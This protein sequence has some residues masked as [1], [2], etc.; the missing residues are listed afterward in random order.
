MKETTTVRV[1]RATR[2]EL[3]RLARHR[4]A[5]VA[6]TVARAV[7]LLR[8]EAMGQELAEPLADEELDWLDADAR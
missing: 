6:D 8:Q 3:R 4:N 7:R 1:D 2:D 5:T